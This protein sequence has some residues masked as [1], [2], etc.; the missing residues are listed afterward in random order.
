MSLKCIDQDIIGHFFGSHSVNL[1]PVVRLFLM[2]KQLCFYPT[3][4]KKKGTFGFEV[5]QV[6]DLMSANALQ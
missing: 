3:E 6:N 5:V 4:R 1:V 2:T